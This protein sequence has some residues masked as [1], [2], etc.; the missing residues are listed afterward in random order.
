MLERWAVVC[1]LL[2]VVDGLV[3]VWVVAY[4]FR[5]SIGC[6]CCWLRGMCLSLCVLEVVFWF[7]WCVTR[8]GSVIVGASVRV[9]SWDLRVLFPWGVLWR[10]SSFAVTPR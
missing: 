1:L 8:F 5:L 7:C 6:S 3:G 10:I 4:V 2:V 9:V